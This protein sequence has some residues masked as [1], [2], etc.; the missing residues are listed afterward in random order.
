ML[1]ERSNTYR[2]HIRQPE[3]DAES[4]VTTCGFGNFQIMLY[5]AIQEDSKI[6]ESHMRHILLKNLNLR[7]IKNTSK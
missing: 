6:I 2:Q 1:K 7:L 4:H 5:F 3:L